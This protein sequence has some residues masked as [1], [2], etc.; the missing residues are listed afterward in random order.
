MTDTSK[1]ILSAVLCAVLT[2][3]GIKLCELYERNRMRPNEAINAK[4]ETLIVRDTITLLKPIS[5]TKRVVE[6][7]LVP[8]T[9][10]IY[11]HDTLYVYLD[12]EQIQWRD[13]LCEVYASG[14]NPRV[15]SVRHYRESKIITIETQP[16]VKV[17]AN[18]GVGL[19][20]GYGASKDG[21]SPYIGVG[22]NYNILSW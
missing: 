10:T 16:P 15:D 5:V 12:R 21:L 13:S 17:K 1:R 19:Q 11:V 18:W 22:L 2:N 8:A 3:I 6:R 20:A 4:V 14:I 9:D 7:E